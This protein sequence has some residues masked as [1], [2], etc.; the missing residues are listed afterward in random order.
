VKDEYWHEILEFIQTWNQKYKIPTEFIVDSFP[1]SVC[2]NI[3]IQRCRIYQGEEFRGYN[4][5]KREYFYGLKATVITTRYGCP[6]K[7]IL[8]PGRE[9]DIVPFRVMNPDLPAGSELYGDSAYTDY[10]FEGRLLREKKIK[11]VVQRKSN[12]K[13]PLTFPEYTSLKMIRG[14]IETAFGKL[15]EMLP[16]KIHAV[17]AAG[18]ELKVMGFIVGFATTFIC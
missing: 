16:R 9:H 1:V 8:C 5:S 3:R 7:M 14:N 17:T 2:R 11:M 6:F 4:K 15:S 13:R 10:D 18:F 12:S